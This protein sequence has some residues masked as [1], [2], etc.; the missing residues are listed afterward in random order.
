V[1][2]VSNN[3]GNNDTTQTVIDTPNVTPINNEK[4]IKQIN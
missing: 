2:A 4:E 1:E 3:G